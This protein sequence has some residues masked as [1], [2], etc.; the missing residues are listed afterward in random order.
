MGLHQPGHHAVHRVL[1][2][3]QVKCTCVYIYMYDDMVFIN[4]GTYM[5]MYMYMYV[6][7]Y[8]Y[9]CIYTH[10]GFFQGGG[11]G[12]RAGVICPPLAKFIPFS[13]GIIRF[14]PFWKGIISHTH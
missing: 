7:I 5:Y 1:W 4:C 10:Q 14:I 12:W 9:V 13:K 11:G 2:H 3:T 6:Y 8:M